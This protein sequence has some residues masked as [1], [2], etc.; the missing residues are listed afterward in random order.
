MANIER[1]LLSL[2][3]LFIAL[4]GVLPLTNFVGHSHWE[5]IQWLPTADN[6]RSW[7]FLFDIIANMA[8]FLPLGYLLS[9]SSATTR[10]SI[11]LTAGI[12]GLLSLSI[13][14]FQVYCHN[15]HPSPVDLFSNISGGL[16]GTIISH[17][18]QHINTTLHNDTPTPNPP[19]HTPAP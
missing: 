14:C 1:T 19:D 13:E 6:F 11:L 2:W 8:L 4:V 10:R 3:A 15:R 5:Y 16:I 9:Q 12:A 7:R 17:Y 18:R